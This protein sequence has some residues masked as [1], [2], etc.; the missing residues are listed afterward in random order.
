MADNS[1]ILVTSEQK[2]LYVVLRDL[3]SGSQ[4]PADFPVEL[5]GTEP[6]WTLGDKALLAEVFRITGDESN[7]THFMSA[8]PCIFGTERFA[9]V[10]NW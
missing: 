5:L 2:N 3:L 6:V 10:N 9:F 8:Y 4:L 7:L 1:G